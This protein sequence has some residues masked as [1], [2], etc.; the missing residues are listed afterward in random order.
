MKE[1]VLHIVLFENRLIL[2]LFQDKSLLR[3]LAIANQFDSM[4]DG[5][6]D[7][8]M[9]LVYSDSAK[10]SSRRK[11]SEHVNRQFR[12]RE[13]HRRGSLPNLQYVGECSHT[14]RSELDLSELVQGM[15]SSAID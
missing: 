13:L 9:R 6:P 8:R 4:D 15:Q 3:S 12:H 7:S 11:Y 2:T 1:E 14:K 10:S 5:D